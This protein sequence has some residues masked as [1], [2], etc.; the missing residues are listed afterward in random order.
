M[1]GLKMKY[2]LPLIII[3]LLT[4]CSEPVKEPVKEIVKEPT[5][6]EI[7]RKKVDIATQELAREGKIAIAD[8]AKDPGSVKFKDLKVYAQNITEG[9]ETIVLT[10]LC[11]EVNMKNGFGG[12]TGYKKFFYGGTDRTSL[13]DFELTAG[14]YKMYC[15]VDG[16]GEI[17][18]IAP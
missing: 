7:A 8:L 11:G 17:T 10:T 15:K 14:L 18:D 3:I 9:S 16:N 2:T 6:E 13:V 5:A 12:Y 1:K 4:A